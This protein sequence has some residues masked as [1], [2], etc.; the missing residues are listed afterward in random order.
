MSFQPLGRASGFGRRKAGA[1]E[2]VGT[3][4]N[5]GLSLESHQILP[6]DLPSP[7]TAGPASQCR[8]MQGRRLWSVLHFS[9][10]TCFSSVKGASSGSTSGHGQPG[11][12]KE[13]RSCMKSG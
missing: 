6:A 7:F 1:S 4:G 8:E 5:T 13:G 9:S 10:Y 2:D 12:Q 3:R 11:S